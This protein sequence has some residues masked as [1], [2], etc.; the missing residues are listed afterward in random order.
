MTGPDNRGFLGVTSFHVGGTCVADTYR[1]L[2]DRGRRR[3]E[4]VVLWPGLRTGDRIDVPEALVPRQT[5][6]RTVSGL[7]YEIHEDEL[8]RIGDALMDRGLVLPIQVHSHPGE[9]YHS[10]VDDAG[11]AVG[12]VGGLSVV[13]P[14][15]AFGPPDPDLWA[16]YRLIPREGWVELTPAERRALILID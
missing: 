12:T 15:F 1:F 2:R 13:V 10:E 16:V 4:G 11:P 8:A 14:D 3:V 7:R 9:A 6:Y 5:A